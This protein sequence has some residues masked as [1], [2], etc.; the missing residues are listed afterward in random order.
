M[1]KNR[2]LLLPIYLIINVFLVMFGS[3]L[4]MIKKIKTIQY[5]RMYIV[6]L[7]INL[8]IILIGYLYNKKTKRKISLDR[9]DLLIGLIIVFGII[10][11]CFAINKQSA[12]FGFRGRYEGLF[13]IMYYFSILFLSSFCKEEYKKYIIYSI[14]LCGLIEG[15]YAVFQ[16]TGLLKVFTYIN[17]GKP[18][19]TGFTTNP[20]FFGTF[21]LLCLSYSIGFFVDNEKFIKKVIYYVLLVFF[22]ICLL[23]SNTLSTIVGLIVLLMY[24]L[25]YSIKN[26]KIISYIIII[27]TIII[28][29]LFITKLGYTGILGDLIKTK[30]QTVEIS[31][32]NIQDNYGSNRIYIWKKAVKRIPFFFLNGAGIDNFYYAFGKKP[33]IIKEFFYIDK[34]HNE[35]LQILICEGF[36]AFVTYMLFYGILVLRGIKNSFNDKKVYLILPV[37]GYL[38]QAFFNISV[39]EVAP[40]VY[41]SLGLCIERNKREKTSKGK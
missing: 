7:I 33:L 16:K 2:E 15:T 18:W 9:I 1:K 22:M 19:A 29:T 6:L 21:M 5:S 23:L 26:K 8:L 41:I 38:T 4:T 3:Y 17:N 25:V 36:Y 32:G 24:L 28:I 20:N 12:F 10:S 11:S 34:A 39:I 35:Y 13:Q 30:N 37:I 27:T 40:F 14:L 31:K